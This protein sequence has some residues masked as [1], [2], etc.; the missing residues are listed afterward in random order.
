MQQR[1]Y[2]L[3]RVKYSL[4]ALLEKKVSQYLLSTLLNHRELELR[5]TLEMIM[6]EFHSMDED[7]E[8]QTALS[9]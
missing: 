2:G 8:A 9:D 4:F 5:G 7:A 6:S 1:P 3:K